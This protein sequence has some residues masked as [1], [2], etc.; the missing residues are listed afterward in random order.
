LIERAQFRHL[1]APRPRDAHKGSFGHVLVIAGSRGKTGAAA[2]SGMAALRAGAGLVTVASTERA[3]PVIAS[4]AAELMTEPLPE[5]EAGSI[6]MRAFEAGALPKIVKGMTVLAMGPG[7]T[8]HP[9]TAAMVRRAFDTFEQPM[10]VDADA[11]N[12]LAGTDWSG[13]GRTRVLTPHPGEMSRL[14]G[15]PASEI[16]K[17]R[18]AAARSLAC[19][20][21]VSVVLKGQRTL[22]AF[23]D[24]RVWI[25]PTGTPAMATGGT[26]DIL[27]GLISGFLAQF[28]QEPEQAIAAAVYLHGLAGELGAHDLGEKCLIATDLLRYLPRAMELCAHVSDRL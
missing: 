10:V 28:P 22:I 4:H 8:T 1:F 23:A 5:T 18:V 7:M 27:T 19:E 3:L 11:L 21:Q 2:M 14:T 17:D 13:R 6:S 16:Q 9:E 25:N 12:A 15:K 24:G 26:G 20:R